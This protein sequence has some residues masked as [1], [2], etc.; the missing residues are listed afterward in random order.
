MHLSWYS[1][2]YWVQCYQFGLGTY[3]VLFV[4]LLTWAYVII[5]DLFVCV[6]SLCLLFWLCV[7]LWL[8][9][10]STWCSILKHSSIS[11]GVYSSRLWYLWATYG[12]RYHSGI[13]TLPPTRNEEEVIQHHNSFSDSRSHITTDWRISSTSKNQH[14]HQL[15]LQLICDQISAHRTSNL[16]LRWSSTNSRISLDLGSES[17]LLRPRL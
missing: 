2:F 12:V 6:F 14:H 4:Y 9:K 16:E 7:N 3:L 17:Q 8:E 1:G 11:L 10:E 15:W 13:I 5:W